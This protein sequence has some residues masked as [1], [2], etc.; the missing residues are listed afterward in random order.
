MCAQPG[1]GSLDSRMDVLW[2]PLLEC[3]QLAACRSNELL[4]PDLPA[5]LFT[6]CLTTP[7]EAPLQWFV[8]EILLIK[9][10]TTDMLKKISG[11]LND[12]RTPL[13]E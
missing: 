9:N 7:I 1:V 8:S 10:I 3:I 6:C 5:D 12:K 2:T 4:H 11:R 13:E